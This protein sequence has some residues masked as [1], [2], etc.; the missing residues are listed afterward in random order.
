MF[1]SNYYILFRRTKTEV[2]KKSKVVGI[3]FRIIK[4]YEFNLIDNINEHMEE[5]ESKFD[6]ECFITKIKK[7]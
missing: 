5:I 4:S 3:F 1:K 7:I 6:C 2:G